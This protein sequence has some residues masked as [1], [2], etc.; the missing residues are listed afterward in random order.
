[1][2]DTKIIKSSNISEYQRLKSL[3]YRT[4]WTGNFQI[5][6]VRNVLDVEYICTGKLRNGYDPEMQD[7]AS[8]YWCK[9]FNVII[10]MVESGFFRCM[11]QLAET[12]DEAHWLLANHP[13]SR[14]V[15]N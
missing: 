1:M 15:L 2:L 14:A 10:A 3:G 12:R 7:D 8:F 13:D 6:M 9:T 11:S 5:A 4:Q